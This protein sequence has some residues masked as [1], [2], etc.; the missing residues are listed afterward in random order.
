MTFQGVPLGPYELPRR[1]G[2]AHLYRL[3][4]P[5]AEHVL[6][7]AKE[8]ELPLAEVQFSY[9]DHGSKISIL[10]SLRGQSGT[11]TVSLF[12]VESMDQAE[13]HFISAACTD[14]GTLLDEEQAR[15]MLSLPASVV[16]PVLDL[17]SPESLAQF[18]ARR[19]AELQRHISER[20]ALFYESEAEKIDGWAD[21]LKVGLER[22]IKEMDR[23]IKDTRRNAATALTLEEKLASQKQIKAIESQRND[24]RRS[25]FEAQDAID[26]QREQ[27]IGKIEGKLQQASSMAILLTIRWQLH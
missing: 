8:R 18:T 12:S 13:D 22:E 14:A 4:H 5:L 9:A 10:E 27:L 3:G 6:T 19:Q 23:L 11:L 26:T 1:S 21:D 17:P 15:R 25:L 7:Q 2:E 24:K 20:N 16:G